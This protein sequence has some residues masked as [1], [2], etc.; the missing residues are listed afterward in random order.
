MAF[1]RPPSAAL[2]K[3][4][5]VNSAVGLAAYGGYPDVELGSP[6][7]PYQGFGR[8]LLNSTMPTA[9]PPDEDVR[10]T[11]ALWVDDLRALSA[12]SYVKYVWRAHEAFCDGGSDACS[13]R[14][15]VTVTWMDP[16][17]VVTA[18]K[19]LLHD[20]DLVVYG[21]GVGFHHANGGDGWDEDNNVER[22]VIDGVAVGAEVAIVAR[23]ER[24]RRQW[25]AELLGRDRG[26]RVH[27]LRR[28]R[29]RPHRHRDADARADDQRRADAHAVVPADAC[30]D[31]VLHA[32]DGL[33]VRRI[34]AD[35][36][37]QADELRGLDRGRR[38]DA[39]VRF[40]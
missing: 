14:L 2:V 25:H 20:L 29:R 23:A 39:G 26:R 24:A 22:V 10:G 6:P 21:G 15:S 30:A 12:G 9:P 38:C 1:E 40:G 4:V 8:I 18:D 7:E 27:D 31:I 32:D 33:G 17:N 28:A 35:A 11:T 19:Q 13:A 37:R 16:A 5:L 36:P 3:A 34:R